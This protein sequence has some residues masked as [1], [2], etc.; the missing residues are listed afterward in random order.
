MSVVSQRFPECYR[1]QAPKTLWLCK[2]LAPG[3]SRRASPDSSS[4]RREWML[5]T[6]SLWIEGIPWRKAGSRNRRCGINGAGPPRVEGGKGQAEAVQEK[7]NSC[8][9][10]AGDLP[11]AQ[12]AAADTSCPQSSALP[13]WDAFQTGRASSCCSAPRRSC[14]FLACFDSASS[15]ADG[16]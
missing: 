2:N 10:C 8:L 14:A 5:S 4:Q 12:E 3:Q 9:R 16:V 6:H 1:L 11:L 15:R 13:S 7:N